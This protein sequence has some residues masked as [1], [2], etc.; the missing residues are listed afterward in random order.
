[1]TEQDGPGPGGTD[2]P[3]RV[4]YEEAGAIA[5]II[6]DR[7]TKLNALNV[8]MFEGLIDA[9]A[10]AAASPAVRVCILRGTG[11]AFAAGADIDLYQGT[12]TAAI[13]AFMELGRRATDALAGCPHPVIASVHGYALGGG[14]E[15]ALA[16]D[17]IVAAESTRLGLPE[18]T[19]GLMPGGGG[20]Q[21]LPRLIGRSRAND[22]LMT[23]RSITATEA[24]VWGLINRVAP[25]D[26][27]MEATDELAAVVARRAPIAVT[28]GKRL[29]VDGLEQPLSIALGHERESTL[30]LYATDDAKE[31]ID[32]FVEKRK[33][34][35]H[36]R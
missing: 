26:G 17:L 11:R 25:D 7:P 10:A 28:T 22:L 15:L 36:G 21:R 1:M 18:V 13:R 29:V 6:L 19:L 5:H 32:A 20:T 33:P 2:D 3:G 35:F 14:L 31:G 12:P 4:R 8:T 34:T 24:L 9:L 30:H 27:L 23:G 16:C